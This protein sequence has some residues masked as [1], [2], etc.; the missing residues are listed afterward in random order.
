M[1]FGL[2]NTIF[3]SLFNKNFGITAAPIKKAINAIASVMNKLSETGFMD[4]DKN[5]AKTKRTISGLKI[6]D[7]RITLLFRKFKKF[8]LGYNFLKKLLSH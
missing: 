2:N 8:S 1:S 3:S 5:N 7:L 4:N 6:C